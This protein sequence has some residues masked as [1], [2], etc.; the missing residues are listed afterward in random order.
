VVGSQTARN[1][2]VAI[3]PHPARRDVAWSVV[4]WGN[5]LAGTDDDSRSGMMPS[6][7]GACGNTESD[8]KA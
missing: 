7:G 8:Q 4:A 5:G 2:V 6:C 3:D 1:G